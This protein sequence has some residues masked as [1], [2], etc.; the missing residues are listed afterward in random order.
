MMINAAT[1]H[2]TNEPKN[3]SILPAL[4]SRTSMPLSTTADCWKKI[5]HGVIVVPMFAMTNVI[6]AAPGRMPHM[7]GR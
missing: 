1:T 7:F 6:I 3:V 4:M 5:C 2:V